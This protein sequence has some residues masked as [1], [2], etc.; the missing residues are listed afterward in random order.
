MLLISLKNDSHFTRL[1]FEQPLDE[2]A[3]MVTFDQLGFR[4]LVHFD[5]LLNRYIKWITYYEYLGHISQ[6]FLDQLLERAAKSYSLSVHKPVHEE[7]LAYQKDQYQILD[8]TS[9]THSNT[10]PSNKTC[11]TLDIK[12][13][14]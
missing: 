13:G 11:S 10:R 3:G 14:C 6:T 7:V 8:M 12:V 5:V 4:D 9:E 2:L 1:Y